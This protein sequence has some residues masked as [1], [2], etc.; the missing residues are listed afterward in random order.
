LPGIDVVVVPWNEDNEATLIRQMD[1]GIMPLPDASW[2]KGKC[3]YKLIQYMAC[4]VPVIASPVGV[5][6]DIVTQSQSGMLADT[7]SEWSNALSLLLRSVEHR[8]QFGAAGRQAV[9]R[10]YCLEVQAPVLSKILHT[11]IS[12]D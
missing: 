5:N 12:R 10:T 3:G 6:V 9:E 2:E 1:I 8:R 7:L 11:A 4:A